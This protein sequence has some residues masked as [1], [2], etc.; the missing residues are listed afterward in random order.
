M[1]VYDKKV[2]SIKDVEV[3]FDINTGAL[4]E[5]AVIC[6]GI[7]K[8]GSTMLHKIV[9]QMAELKGYLPVDIPGVMFSNGLTVSDWKTDKRIGEIFV[10]GN[11]YTGFRAFPSLFSSMPAY[12][13]ARKVFMFR[14]PRDALV[15]QYFS[16]AYSH[17]IPEREG[18]GR[19]L[20]LA[21]REEALNTDINEY[22]LTKSA[23][24]R[25]TCMEYIPL[26]HDDSCLKLRYEEYVFQKKRLIF[27][28]A[29]QY[30]WELSDD[31]AE[32][33]LKDVD[34]VP[35]EENEKRFVRKAIPG[36]HREK[37]E[38]ST[39]RKLSHRF[40][41]VLEEFDYY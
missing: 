1:S 22:V 24:L 13:S 6:F 15:S 7:R 32:S 23:A 29:K 36:D 21:K 34:F 2:I 11:V 31:E 14:D 3:S 9:N 35:E 39:I 16:D 5:N 30:G 10:G 25:Q 4:G 38:K 18:K 17:K 19:D 27:H 26:L 33:I 41:R 28:I 20:F 40:G 8:S 37:L 12:K